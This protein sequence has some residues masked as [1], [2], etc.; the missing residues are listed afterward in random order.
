VSQGSYNAPGNV[1]GGTP[2]ARIDDNEV[3]AVVRR[4]SHLYLRN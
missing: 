1:L 2:R 3:D 4:K